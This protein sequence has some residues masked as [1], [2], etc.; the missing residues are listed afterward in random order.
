MCFDINE[1]IEL[2]KCYG[3]SFYV[4]D[5]EKFKSNYS[6]LLESFRVFFT[7]TFIAY[8]YKT[9]YIP[10]LCETI[11]DMG[12]YAEVVSEMEYDLAKKIGVPEFKIVYNG[13]YKSEKVMRELLLNGG[14][15]NIDCLSEC[16]YVLELA[17]QFSDRKFKIGLRCNY[18]LDEESISRFGVDVNGEEL[19]IILK[20]ISSRDNIYLTGLHCHFAPRALPVWEIKIKGLISFLEKENFESLEYICVGG[21]LFGKMPTV[22]QM[23][24]DV[25][26]P[27]FNEYA[28]CIAVPI[29]AYLEKS[30][31]KNIKLFIEPGTALAGDTMCFASK[32]ISIK[33]IREKNLATLSGSIYNINPTLNTKN[34]PICIVHR[35]NSE[36]EYFDDIDFGGYT[37]IESDYLYKGYSGKVGVGDYVIFSNVGSYSVVLKPPFIMPN[38]PIIEFNKERLTKIAKRA[39]MFDDIFQTYQ[40]GQVE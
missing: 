1:L 33:K 27:T 20:I 13:P 10:R 30:G 12:G 9:N 35:N 21:G 28:E 32:V 4:L 3:N 37:C 16:K 7:N 25:T 23:Q 29:C 17:K 36:E 31:K 11:N 24:F 18:A 39:E 19:Q 14:M 15:V 40:F 22:L 34:P 26:I 38:F 5:T 2:E 6:E 8:S